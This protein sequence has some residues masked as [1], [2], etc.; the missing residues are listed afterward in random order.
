MQQI[1]GTVV[2]ARFAFVEQ[3][4]GRP[5]VQQILDSLPKED[6]DQLRTIL[7]VKWYPLEIGRRVDDA[8][9]KVLGG[10]DPAVFERLGVASADANLATLHKSF[11]AP[12][13]PHAFLGKAPQIYSLYYEQGRRTY[14][15]TG[16][17]SGVLTTFEAETFSAPDCLTVIGWYRRALEM[18][19]A[20]GVRI[21]HPIC[22]A[23]GGDVC[24]YEVSWSAVN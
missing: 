22:R 13:K 15:Q 6:A 7:S 10:G 3:H 11:L 14:E 8:I 17:N 5:G 21:E 9:V 20:S 12:G 2:K 1:K 19:G 23:A 16:E 4:W 18:C 24:R